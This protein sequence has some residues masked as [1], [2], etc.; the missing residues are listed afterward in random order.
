MQDGQV[1]QTVNLSFRVEKGMRLYTH[2]EDIYRCLILDN[3]S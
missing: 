2:P 1:R 3:I